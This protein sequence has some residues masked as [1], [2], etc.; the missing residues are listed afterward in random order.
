MAG[1]RLESKEQRKYYN[2][3]C[4]VNKIQKK[5]KAG[6]GGGG[7]VVKVTNTGQ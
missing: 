1:L 2:V 6:G 7:A 3:I 4:K 5:K